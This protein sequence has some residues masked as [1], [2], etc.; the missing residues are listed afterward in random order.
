MHGHRFHRTIRS[1]SSA[2]KLVRL[3][4]RGQSRNAERGPKVQGWRRGYFGGVAYPPTQSRASGAPPSRFVR[5][6]EV[7]HV[8]HLPASSFT[9]LDPPN[10]S[11]FTPPPPTYTCKD[12]LE[13]RSGMKAARLGE[14]PERLVVRGESRVTARRHHCCSEEKREY[15]TSH[16]RGSWGHSSLCDSTHV[17]ALRCQLLPEARRYYRPFDPFLR[18]RIR[19]SALRR[20]EKAKEGGHRVETMFLTILHLSPVAREMVV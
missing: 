11:F 10:R 1:Q 7:P 12:E 17:K 3:K 9:I 15:F 5:K 8:H 19:A 2:G 4:G 20:Q 16:A 6:A 13:R 18:W 14:Q